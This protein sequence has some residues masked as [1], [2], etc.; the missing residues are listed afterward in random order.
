MRT[1]IL[2]VSIIGLSLLL[3]SCGKG[4]IE[5]KI[6]GDWEQ[7]SVGQIPEGTEIKWTFAADHSLY[8]TTTTN[9]GITIDTAG[10]FR[11]QVILHSVYIDNLS[12]AVDGNYL[13]HDLKNYLSIQRVELTNGH[14]DGSYLWKEFEKL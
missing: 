8:Q 6:I 12:S 11:G 10:C 3:G 2:I 1:I 14:G 7:L 9:T 13:I 4:S 5:D